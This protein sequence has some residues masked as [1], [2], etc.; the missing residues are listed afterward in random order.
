MFLYNHNYTYK[1]NSLS[2]DKSVCIQ[3]CQCMD[4]LLTY[5]RYFYDLF[6][7]QYIDQKAITRSE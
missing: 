4:W 2:Y 3:Y 6:M 7:L 5:E 1:D